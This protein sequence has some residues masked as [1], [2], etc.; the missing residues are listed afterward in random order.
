MTGLDRR[1]RPGKIWIAGETDQGHV[2]AGSDVEGGRECRWEQTRPI[3]DTGRE[4]AGEIREARPSQICVVPVHSPKR[5][6]STSALLT[7]LIPCSNHTSYSRCV[8]TG[9]IPEEGPLFWGV[10]PGPLCTLYIRG[11]CSPGV[12]LQAAVQAPGVAPEVPEVGSTSALSFLGRHRVECGK[13]QKNSPTPSPRTA[14]LLLE[15]E[16]LPSI[17][18]S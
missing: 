17:H 4:V 3:R 9:H 5:S 7:V 16:I 15:S 12:P 18:T 11:L 6:C 13:L 2:G 1:W 14:C 10:L 8:S